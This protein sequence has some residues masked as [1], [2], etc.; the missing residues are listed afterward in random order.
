MRQDIVDIMKVLKCDEA[1]AN[2]ILDQMIDDGLDFSEC[3]KS[4]FNR[5]AKDAVNSIKIFK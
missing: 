5:A 4:L 3:T 1:Y 2:T